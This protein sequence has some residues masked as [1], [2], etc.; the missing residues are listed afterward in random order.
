VFFLYGSFIFKYSLFL[1]E[2]ENTRASY[3]T[4]R[5]IINVITI[6]VQR[7]RKNKNNLRLHERIWNRM[8]H[9]CSDVTSENN[10]HAHCRALQLLLYTWYFKRSPY[11]FT[12]HRTVSIVAHNYAYFARMYTHTYAHYSAAAVWIISS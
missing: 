8:F 9:S 2:R 3:D 5:I 1:S 10:V 6:Y 4:G 7:E 11:G 12:Y